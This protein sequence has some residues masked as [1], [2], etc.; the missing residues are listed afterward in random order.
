MISIVD[1]REN[2]P[3]SEALLLVR[4]TG[5]DLKP[6]QGNEESSGSGSWIDLPNL[7][8]TFLSDEFRVNLY[9]DMKSSESIVIKP[10]TRGG[11]VRESHETLAFVVKSCRTQ[12]FHVGT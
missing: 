1:R 9:L 8:S 12:N 10:K 7:V 4:V 5:L 2:N 6:E 3:P 11:T